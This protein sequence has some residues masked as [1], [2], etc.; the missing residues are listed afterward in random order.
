MLMDSTRILS[1]Q[2]N[3]TA[4]PRV[5][6]LI[7][8]LTLLAVWFA[9]LRPTAD[10]AGTANSIGL[11]LI[12]GGMVSAWAGR[13]LWT[14]LACTISIMIAVF[15]FIVELGN[16][17]G[18]LVNAATADAVALLIVSIGVLMVISR[19]TNSAFSA[20]TVF[21]LVQIIQYSCTSLLA[22]AGGIP[23]LGHLL[24]SSPFSSA[25]HFLIGTALLLQLMLRPTATTAQAMTWPQAAT[26]SVIFSILST[27]FVVSSGF[28]GMAIAVSGTAL[29]A[30]AFLGC[31]SAVTRREMFRLHLRLRRKARNQSKQQDALIAARADYEELYEQ[32]PIGVM[33]TVDT[34]RIVGA[35]SRMCEVLGYENV[36]QMTATDLRALFFDPERRR[37]DFLA[38]KNSGDREW[39]GD[40]EMLKRDGSTILARFTGSRVNDAHGNLRYVLTCYEDVT[41][42]RNTAREI[43]KLES[44]LRLTHKLEA[45]GRLAAGVAHE[46]NTP[47]Q[48]VGDSVFFLASAYDDLR[49]LARGL[50]EHLRKVAADAG[51]SVDEAI[52]ALEEEADLEYLDESVTGSFERTQDGVKSVAEIVRS[53]KEFA[54]PNDKTRSLNDINGLLSNTLTVSRSMYVA[55]ANV[56]TDF[57]ELP[58]TFCFP[59]ELNQVFV[60]LVVNAAHAI[61]KANQTLGR[62]MGEI[63]ITTRLVDHNIQIQIS[64]DGTGMPAAV[65]KRIFDPFFTTKEVGKGTGQG[66]AI[67]HS[68]IAEKHA[69]AIEVSSESGK[70][71]TFTV[72]I[73]LRE[74]AGGA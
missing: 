47:M 43:K 28:A 3:A 48:Y 67:A 6:Y 20:L 59:G 18:A 10:L 5:L 66:L 62:P 4:R 42:Q 49:A 1:T 38:W 54:Y 56:V 27:M 74:S 17:N 15:L 2:L 61:E 37:R 21:V 39:S 72:S 14:R 71:T 40:V 51:L 19:S 44:D 33:K 32:V 12:S 69:G 73:P 35:N 24:Q 64:D 7:A 46:I 9:G 68:I 36:D 60:N 26:I 63:K 53:M 50:T 57:G 45:V 8:P 11:A 52:S 23:E 31:T 41:A 70:G 30:I 58:P 55:A 25:I 34:G 16:E 65:Q 22:E 29:I 13:T